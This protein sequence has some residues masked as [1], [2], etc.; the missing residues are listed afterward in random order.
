MRLVLKKQ[1]FTLVMEDFLLSNAER[2]NI[3][4]LLS[5]DKKLNFNRIVQ[6]TGIRSNKLSYQLN[7]MKENNFIIN[8]DGNYSLSL[9]AQRLIPY[10][11][12][13]F[14]KEVGVLPVV[15][16]IVRNGQRIL[17]LQ[18]KKCL[19]KAIGACLAASRS[20]EK[21][22]LKPSRE[23]YL[24]KPALKRNSINATASSTNG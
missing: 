5:E 21:P 17:L 20:A 3:F 16:G 22:S 14:K 11:S 7:L 18:R 15:L 23:K 19:T 13:I 1:Y 9:E 24:K 8:Q 12:Q 4:K 2:M 6:L 10:F